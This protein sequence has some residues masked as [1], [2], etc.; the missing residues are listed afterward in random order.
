MNCYVIMCDDRPIMG[1]KLHA[2]MASRK[3][4]FD[5]YVADS[6]RCRRWS[7]QVPFFDYAYCYQSAAKRRE[8]NVAHNFR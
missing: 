2:E 7:R 6:E 1:P 8:L 3:A 5:A 4:D